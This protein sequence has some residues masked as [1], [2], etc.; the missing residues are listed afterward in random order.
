M[1]LLTDPSTAFPDSHISIISNFHEYLTSCYNNSI[2]RWWMCVPIYLWCNKRLKITLT[3]GKMSSVHLFSLMKWWHYIYTI[4]RLNKV[5]WQNQLEKPQN[6]QKRDT[7]LQSNRT[8]SL[9]RS[10]CHW[11]DLSNNDAALTQKRKEL[12]LY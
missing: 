2:R 12:Y 3:F 7:K 1:I 11:I 9:P 6:P 10:W 4:I 5:M 8:N